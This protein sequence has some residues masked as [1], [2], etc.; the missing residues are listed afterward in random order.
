MAS[1]ISDS[2]TLLRGA[3]K[4]SYSGGAVLHTPYNFWTTDDTELKFYLVIDIP[5]TA[6][7]LSHY[8]GSE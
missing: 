7:L 6:L 2:L 4:T 1:A 3:L 8:F 5:G